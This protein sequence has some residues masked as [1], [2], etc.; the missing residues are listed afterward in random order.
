MKVSVEHWN[1]IDTKMCCVILDDPCSHSNEE[2]NDGDGEY[3][4]IVDATLHFYASVV[5]LTVHMPYFPMPVSISDV[6]DDMPIMD[7]VPFS[8]AG[9]G[10]RYTQFEDEERLADGNWSYNDE[11]KTE[12]MFNTM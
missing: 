2:S 12:I 1:Y 4:H 6:D 9:E 10:R 11:L 5:V 3:N 7:P 8:Y